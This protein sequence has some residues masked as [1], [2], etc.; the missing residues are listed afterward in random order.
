MNGRYEYDFIDECR[1]GPCDIY[2]G[3]SGFL[4]RPDQRRKTKRGKR[5][6]KNCVTNP[7]ESSREFRLLHL[8]FDTVT[9]FC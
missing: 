5:K 8:V 1:E 7:E 4:G 3:Q 9:K 2:L 6:W